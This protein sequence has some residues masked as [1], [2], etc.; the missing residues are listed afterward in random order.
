MTNNGH[1]LSLFFIIFFFLSGEE[2][3]IYIHIRF[4]SSYFYQ[5]KFLSFNVLFLLFFFIKLRPNIKKTPYHPNPFIRQKRRYIDTF[6]IIVLY[7][8]Q[9][10]SRTLSFNIYQVLPVITKN[11]NKLK[12][13]KG[14]EKQLTPSYLLLRVLNVNIHLKPFICRCNTFFVV[15][16]WWER[17]LQSNYTQ[18]WNVENY[19]HPLTRFL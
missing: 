3:H 19:A 1:F 11:K 10:L 7:N 15:V 2:I 9:I 4:D 5:N 8:I 18:T 12:I 13:V 16:L 6:I 14:E 17:F